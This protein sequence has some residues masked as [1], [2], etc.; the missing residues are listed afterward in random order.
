MS[1]LPTVSLERAQA[2]D[3]AWQVQLPG[4]PGLLL[5]I[6]RLPAAMGHFGPPYMY[7]FSHLGAATFSPTYRSIL[8][9]TATGCNPWNSSFGGRS[10]AFSGSYGPTSS[11]G[12]VGVPGYGGWSGNFGGQQFGITTSAGSSSRGATA[13][14]DSS[15]S[16]GNGDATGHDSGGAA[17]SNCN[18]GSTPSSPGLAPLATAAADAPTTAEGSF[19]AESKYDA[20][21]PYYK[22]T[23]ASIVPITPPAS[24]SAKLRSRVNGV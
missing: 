2:A 16:S 4:L 14:C 10:C 20:K 9:N 15:T 21:L 18:T 12:F 23:E 17:S 7:A 1:L 5:R 19:W 24:P 22:R 6:A 11:G 8:A 3:E 13:S